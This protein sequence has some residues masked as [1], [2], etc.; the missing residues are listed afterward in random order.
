MLCWGMMD[1]ADPN[2]TTVTYL[3]GTSEALGPGWDVMQVVYKCEDH[4]VMRIANHFVIARHPDGTVLRKTD[5]ILDRW[6]RITDADDFR[7]FQNCF[8]DRDKLA[9]EKAASATA[10]REP[11]F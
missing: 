8:D 9:A 3:S 4:G 2:S 11:S 5:I 6:E 1:K 10:G 7:G